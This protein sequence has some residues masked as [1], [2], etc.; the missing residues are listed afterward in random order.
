MGEAVLAAQQIGI[1]VALE[2]VVRLV[3]RLLE[4]EVRRRPGLVLLHAALERRDRLAL[5]LAELLRRRA[6]LEL[7]VVDRAGLAARGES[8]VGAGEERAAERGGSGGPPEDGAGLRRRG[9][10]R[11]RQPERRGARGEGD[12]EPGHLY[13]TTR[14]TAC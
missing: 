1:G 6:V 5:P 12:E 14:L 4:R 7:L 11:R 9:R 2:A 8:R 10:H 13:A 3:E